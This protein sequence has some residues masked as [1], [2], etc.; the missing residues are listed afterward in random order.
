MDTEKQQGRPEMMQEQ[1]LHHKQEKHT[2]ILSIKNQK[3]PN[4][5]KLCKWQLENQRIFQLHTFHIYMCKSSA[6]QS[7]AWRCITIISFTEHL[8][9]NC[10]ALWSFE[11]QVRRVKTQSLLSR[12][13]ILTGRQPKTP[14]IAPSHHVSHLK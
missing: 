14:Y 6:Q 9:N 3:V 4:R 13:Y 10:P 2:D 8:P 5:N 12:R 11:R 1:L 7:C